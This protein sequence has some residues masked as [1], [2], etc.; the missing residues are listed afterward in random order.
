MSLPRLEA[1]RPVQFD[2]R[3]A[4]SEE[5]GQA[6]LS[7]A[8]WKY[9]DDE[10]WSRITSPEVIERTLAA[11]LCMKDVNLAA[12]QRHRS[13]L[14]DERVR[15]LEMGP[16]GRVAWRRALS[17][18]RRWRVGSGNFG[19]AVD[20][21]LHEVRASLAL[22]ERD[23][24][25]VRASAREHRSRTHR[26]EAAIREHRE[27]TRRNDIDPEPHDYKLWSLVNR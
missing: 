2:A 27:A 13:A 7:N 10:V 15:T 14:E 17:E 12:V 11:L 4:D 1:V 16:E 8:V 23:D 9:R 20:R 3:F 24:S 5:L 6:A 22:L 25:F 21:A 19:R 18:Y 26:M